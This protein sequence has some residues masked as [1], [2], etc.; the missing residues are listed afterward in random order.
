MLEN[1]SSLP[2]ILIL[3]AMGTIP[4]AAIFRNEPPRTKGLLLIFQAVCFVA[5]LYLM[6]S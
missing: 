3:W 6:W 1:P 5:G 2:A 4:W